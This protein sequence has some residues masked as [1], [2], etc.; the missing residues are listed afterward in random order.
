MLAD[1]LN[2][3]RYRKSQQQLAKAI[4]NHTKPRQ[5]LVA[6]AGTGI[7]KTFAYLLPALLSG[8]KV[9]ISTGT[10]NLQDQL[11]FKDVP[12]LL[13]LIEAG[14]KVALLKGRGNYLCPHH[15]G[16]HLADPENQTPIEMDQMIRIRSWANGT[17]TGDMAEMDSLAE[18]APIL[19]KVTS[20]NDNC[21]GQKCPEF[22]RCFLKRAR[23]KALAADVVVINHHLF[24]AD[25]SLKET[26]FGELLPKLDW[27]MFDEAHQL[28]DI[29]LNRFGERFNS[30]SLVYLAR[31]VKRLYQLLKDCKSLETKADDLISWSDDLAEALSKF[32][33]SN[34]LELVKVE[35]VI[36][37]LGGVATALAR[38]TKELG[39]HIGRDELADNCYERSARLQGI[40][41]HFIKPE[42]SQV[43]LLE[44]RNQGFSLVSTPLS[45][46]DKLTELYNQY[47][48]AWLFTSAT[49]QVDGNFSYF[50]KQMALDSATTL[51]LDSPFNYQKQ[52]LMCVPRG[53]YEPHDA[54]MADQLTEIADK[55]INAADG[56]TFLLFTSYHMMHQVGERLSRLQTRPL[57]VQGMDSKRQ[58]L[59]RYHAYGNAVLLGTS[60]F[61]EGVDVRGR[62]LCCVMIDKLPF[63]SPDDPLARARVNACERS[64]QDPFTTVQLPQAI[65]ALKQ[66]VGRLIRSEQDQGVLVIGDA[67]LVHRPYGQQ[68]LASLPAMSRT[69]ELDNALI[70]L[71]QLREQ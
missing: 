71:T 45:V 9:A 52:A 53:L 19:R 65:L 47:H 25:S 22:E 28:P 40:V 26:G 24:F 69:R 61:W 35:S 18:D 20:T 7:G 57:L 29:A 33:I 67:R 55:L 31:D 37:T 10:K 46:R 66:G 32:G 62:G 1:K 34:W 2:Q 3:F 15:L 48:C 17:S 12:A 60:A 4:A 13:P 38:L 59:H 39:F 63:V 56:R 41:E 68:F 16:R 49:L 36:Y 70:K 50:T 54:R 44:R 6:E 30:S 8:K 5:V 58:L 11:F 21:L 51:T 14:C 23:A 42:P 27:I 64:G 43:Y